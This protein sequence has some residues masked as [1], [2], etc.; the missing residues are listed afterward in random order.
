M[1]TKNA[2]SAVLKPASGGVLSLALHTFIMM[3][4]WIGVEVSGWL[5]RACKRGAREVVE[6]GVSQ[7]AILLVTSRVTA[8]L[9]EG[10]KVLLVF[11]GDR[12]YEAK[13]ETQ[14]SRRNKRPRRGAGQAHCPAVCYGLEDCSGTPGAV[15]AGHH[16]LVRR[17]QRPFYG[18]ALRS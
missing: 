13:A 17:E 5:H 15:P 10:A 9:G 3:G 12:G 2:V 6:T 16:G 11:D 1:G 18:G 4:R 8:M 14:A 7:E